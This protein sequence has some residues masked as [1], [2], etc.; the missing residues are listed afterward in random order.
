MKSFHGTRKYELVGLLKYGSCLMKFFVLIYEYWLVRSRPDN[1]P[2]LT[3]V[4]CINV[5]LQLVAH[6]D[7]GVRYTDAPQDWEIYSL[8]YRSGQSRVFAFHDACW[9]LLLERAAVREAYSISQIVSHLFN[10]LYSTPCDEKLVWMP[11]H[12]YGG[13]LQFQCSIGNPLFYMKILLLFYFLV[14]TFKLLFIIVDRT[15]CPNHPIL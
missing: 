15:T 14:L 3:G 7:E 10:I 5:S 2:T 8:R 1:S 6:P 9:T 4:G 12:D 11:G 13:V